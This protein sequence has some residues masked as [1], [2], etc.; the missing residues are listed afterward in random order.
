[1]VGIVYQVAVQ[2]GTKIDADS[3]VVV[4]EA[5]KNDIAETISKTLTIP[6]IGI[7][8]GAGCDGQIIVIND[9]LGMNDDFVPKF[10]RQY[11]KQGELIQEAAAKFTD[12]VRKVRYPTD[13]ES[14][15]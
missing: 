11:L 3:D 10:V 5:M 14:Y 13:S 8:A 6:T 1:M 4:L 12:D 9:I 7:G 2:P 15:G